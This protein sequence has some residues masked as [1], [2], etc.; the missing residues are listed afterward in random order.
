MDNPRNEAAENDLYVENRQ[1]L[2]LGLVPITLEAG[3]LNEVTEIAEKYAHRC[4][5]EKIPCRS[6]WR[7]DL[8]RRAQESA[9]APLVAA[10]RVP[11]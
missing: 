6:Y 7:N 11:S 8:R 10:D 5:P 1:L 9:G 4:D 2:D 3:L